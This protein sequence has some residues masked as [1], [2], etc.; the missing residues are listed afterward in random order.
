VVVSHG[1][2][3]DRRRS[4]SRC[5]TGA[6]R[7][8]RAQASV[9]LRGPNLSR[10]TDGFVYR[11]LLP[12]RSWIS[13]TTT[14]SSVVM[15]RTICRS[16][17]ATLNPTCIR[18]IPRGSFAMID[19]KATFTNIGRHFFSS[20]LLNSIHPCGPRC[21]APSFSIPDH[22]ATCRLGDQASSKSQVLAPQT[23]PSLV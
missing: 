1:G 15:V 8:S 23:R 2:A 22:H 13:R 4:A 6:L 21:K 17:M 19:G 5:A 7:N 16:S 20:Y 10:H 18:L 11:A 3:L 14:Y 12:L 9:S